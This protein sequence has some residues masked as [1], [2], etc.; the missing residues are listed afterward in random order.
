[1]AAAISGITS[2]AQVL[3][4]LTYIKCKKIPRSGPIYKT[5]TAAVGICCKNC[6]D[7]SNNV[8]HTMAE[9][10]V[11]S[12]PFLCQNHVNGCTVQDPTI[13]DIEKHEQGCHLALRKIR[14]PNNLPAMLVGYLTYTSCRIKW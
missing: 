10:L 3:E 6:K 14:C 5:T 1:M 9:K 11:S 4:E 8:L 2:V 13:E 7:V 12:L